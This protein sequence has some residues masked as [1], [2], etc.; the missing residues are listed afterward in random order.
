MR[1]D[2]SK[3]RRGAVLKAPPGKIRITIRLDKVVLDGFGNKSRQPEAG[4]TNR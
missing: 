4:T 3:G 2:F 1:K